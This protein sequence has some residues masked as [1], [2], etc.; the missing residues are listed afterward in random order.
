MKIGYCRVSTREQS[1]Q[2]QIDQLKDYG[3]EKIF[4]DIIGGTKVER[5]GLNDMF[6]TLRDGD[7]VVVYKLDRLARGL[8]D[9]IAIVEKF[10]EMKVGLKSLTENIIDT[11]TPSGLF[12]FQLIGV[13]AEFERN[14]IK[15]RTRA[16]LESAKKMGR[17]GGRPTKK[18]SELLKMLK[19]MYDS[20][21]IPVSV[22]C[23]NLNISQTTFYNYLREVKK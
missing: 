11:T 6:N 15:E 23:K 10:K 7:I 8:I 9:L 14:I 4:H 21:D 13:F 20:K 19:A 1:L 18:T 3:C 12:M 17:K 16:G 5:T 22:M 2:S